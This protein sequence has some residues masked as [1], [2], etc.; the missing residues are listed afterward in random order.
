VLGTRYGSPVRD[1]REVSYTELEF[2]TATDAGKDRLV[3]LLDTAAADVGIPPS[4]LIDREFGARQ[5]A[6]RRRVRDSGLLTQSFANP[7]ELGQLVERALRDLARARQAVLSSVPGGAPAGRRVPPFIVPP[8]PAHCERREELLTRARDAL[9]ATS[10]NG[11]ART[12]GLVGMGGGGKSVLARALAR[13]EQVRRA[14][15]QG[16]VWLELGLSPNLLVRHAQL[17]EQFGDPRPAAAD[18]QQALARL[19]HTLAGAACLIVLDNVW[20]R[21]HLQAFELFEPKSALLATTRYKDVLGGYATVPVGPLPEKQSR[22]LLAAWAGAGEDRLP[23]EAEEVAQKCGGLPLALAIA[24][25][26]VADRDHSWHYVCERLRRADLDKLEIQFR[27]YG[28]ENLL[29]VLDASVSD[30]TP[31]QRARYLELAVFDG[32]GNVPVE[33]V[34]RLWRQAGLDDL[35]AEDLRGRFADG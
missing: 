23:S 10:T 31:L 7:A 18:L 3:F 5:D 15:P 26:M 30:L 8:I 16:I 27:D 1:Q 12:V 34:Q 2:K 4:E 25:G 21:E 9:L 17:A 28:Y 13:D 24:G 20:R 22:R 29:L 33:V 14:F 35:D 19:N 6:F 11:A 32:H